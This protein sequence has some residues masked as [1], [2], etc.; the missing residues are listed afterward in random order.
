MIA[1]P[2]ARHAR[3]SLGSPCARVPATTRLSA[4][5]TDY[6]PILKVLEISVRISIIRR[7]PRPSP[8][9]KRLQFPVRPCVSPSPMARKALWRTGWRAAACVPERLGLLPTSVFPEV[10]DRQVIPRRR[11]EVGCRRCPAAYVE[12]TMSVGGSP[13]AS[14]RGVATKNAASPNKCVNKQPCDVL[15]LRRWAP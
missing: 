15:L 7:H 6:S 14:E 4:K 13:V 9:R 2:V 1:V 12:R 10:H 11:T 3:Q 8:G 5:R